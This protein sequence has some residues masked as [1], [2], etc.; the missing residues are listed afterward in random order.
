MPAERVDEV[1]PPLALRGLII[2]DEERYYIPP[3]HRAERYTAKSLA[4]LAC[5]SV[6][7]R[8]L[9]TALTAARAS[10]DLSETQFGAVETSIKNGLMVLTGGPG[11]GKTTTIKAIVAAHLALGHRVALCAPTGRAAKRMHEATGHEARTI[12]RTLEWNPMSARFVKGEQDPIDAELVLVD[13]AS[14]MDVRLAE[15]FA[16]AVA[17]SSTLVLVGDVD[18]LP[19]VG[20]GQVLRDVIESGVCPVVRLVEVFRQAQRSA[21]VR[22]AHAILNGQLPTP[23]P[24]GTRGTGDLFIVRSTDPD[25]IQR[26]LVA[27]VH[28][29]KDVYGLD[30]SDMQ[31]LSPMKGGPAGTYRLN[32]LLQA[33]FNPGDTKRERGTD[34]ALPR[35]GDKVM[36]L[37]NDYERNVFNGDLGTVRRVQAGITYVLMD[38]AEVQYK[39][40]HLEHLSLAYASTVHKVQG[41]EFGGIIV[42]LHGSHHVLLSRALL[43]TAVTRAKKLVVLLGDERAMRRA[44]RNASSHEIHSLLA[45]RLRRSAAK[46]E[47]ERA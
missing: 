13:E 24:S 15:R 21:I 32:E 47:R 36:Q 12:H 38:G 43:Y 34:R 37:R 20:P 3:L 31:V 44:A 27:L 23:T 4:E 28:R 22:G 2:D 45:E 25:V 8:D 1:L 29:M 30:M 11:T 7:P 16:A 6:G 10:A 18:Q 41:S 33:E 40:E 14:M 42:V 19:P 9:E 5:R 46:I 35:P 39:P 17:R 26:K